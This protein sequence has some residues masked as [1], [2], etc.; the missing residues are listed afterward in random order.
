MAEEYGRGFGRV[1]EIRRVSCLY[2]LSFV[3][4]YAKM[5]GVRNRDD[6]VWTVLR[7]R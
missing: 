3:I 4:R 1:C 6:L 5:K 7:Y 2:L